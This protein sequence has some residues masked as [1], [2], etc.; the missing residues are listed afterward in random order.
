MKDTVK[1]KDADGVKQ[2]VGKVLHQVGL[3]EIFTD[4]I[5][6][7]PHLHRARWASAPSATSSPRSATSVGSRRTT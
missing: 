2:D 7:K 3:G 4:I 6:A 5:N 1:I